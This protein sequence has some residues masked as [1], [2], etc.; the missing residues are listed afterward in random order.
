MGHILRMTIT[1]TVGITFIFLV[2]VINLFWISWLGNVKLVA[3]M[4]FAFSIQ[5]FSVSVGIGLMI[6]TTAVVSR[7]IGQG[8]RVLVRNLATST[9]IIAV[10][11]QVAVVILIVIFRED[12]LWFMGAKGET[13]KLASRYLLFS[14]TVLT[15][16]GIRNV[17]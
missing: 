17:R 5:F 13:A 1:G 7:S 6:A 9:M 12:F 10:M 15:S 16:D 4:G 8:N 2:D 11:T 3:A 14:P